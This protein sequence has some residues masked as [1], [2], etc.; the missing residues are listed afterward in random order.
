MK[1]RILLATGIAGALAFTAY[2]QVTV[3][4]VQTIG[5]TD[6]IQVIP[7]GQPTPQNYYATSNL[8]GNYGA[9]LTGNNPE[10]LLIGGD[11]GTN[12]WQR[13]T[14]GSSVTTTTTYGGPDRFFY[15][16]GTNTA[17]TVSR[18]STAGD[19]PT[20]YQYAFKMART[21]GQTGVVQV[22]T[23]QVV[24]SSNAIRLQGQ[25]AELD[26]HAITGSNFSGTGMTAYI[27]TGTGTDEGA[28]KMAYGLNAGGGGGTAWT[29]QANAVAGVISMGASQNGR[30][31]VV[32]A[33]PATA[34]E[35]GVALC[36]T[37]TGTAGTNDYVALSGIQLVPNSALTGVAGTALP[38]NDTRAKGFVRRPAALETLLQQRYAYVLA[39]AAA[40][41]SFPSSCFVTTAN[42]TVKCGL[43]LPVTMRTTP[44]TTISTATSFGIIVTAGTAGTCTTLAATAS[45]NT[46]NV[47]GLTCTTGGTIALG[48][49]TPLIGAAT[50]G[51]ITVSAEL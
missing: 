44:T 17:M 29:G 12:L 16:S 34:T 36:F 33:I 24:E 49:A 39:D 22:C 19:L 35:V 18:S 27:I 40:T 5:S 15:W 30:Y 10:N 32:G 20:G 28:A 1:K 9:T 6:L 8:L 14:T 38:A 37:P 11:A 50:A 41:V 48:S 13:G 42:T 25:T 31:T 7:G 45:S 23:G 21:S 51:T 47:I 4:Q 26:F 2:A 3:P 43:N 46:A